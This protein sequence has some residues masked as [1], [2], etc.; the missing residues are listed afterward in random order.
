MRIAVFS[1]LASGGA[2]IAAWRL[3]RALSDFGHECSFF[4]L[5]SSGNPLQVP[6]LD[7]DDAFWV[8]SLFR[9]WSALTTPE[10]LSAHA[11]ELFSDTLT[12]LHVPSLLLK[13]IRDAELIHLHWVAGMLF[14]PALLSAVAG[15]KVIWTLHDENAFTGGCHYAGMCLNFKSRCCDCP[16]LRKPD[17][18][19]ASA[20]CFDLKKQLYPFLNPSFVAP[21][22]WLAER[23]KPSAL[24]RNFPVTVIPNSLSAESFQPARNKLALRRKLGLPDDAFIILSG[25]EHLSNPRKR[26]SLLFEA[27]DFLSEQ[28]FDIPVVL[29]LYGHGQPP[30]LAFPIHHFGYV[31]DEAIMVDLYGAADIFVHTS[32]QDNLPLSLCEAQACGTP[33]LCFDVGGCSETMI[34]EK[35]GFLVVEATKQALAEKLGTI[36]KN[37]D[38]LEGMSKAARA[39]AA[40]RFNPA[41]VAAAYM[42]LFENAQPAPGLKANDPIFSE[43]LQNQ[44][45]SL[46][47]FLQESSKEFFDQLSDVNNWLNDINGRLNGTD[48]QLNEVYGRLS[49]TDNQLGEVY[50]RLSGT[51]N[52]LGEIYGRLSGIDNQLSGV[53]GRLSG[54][55]NQLSEICGRLSGTDSQL[56]EVYDRLNGTDNQ[57]SEVYGRLSGIDSQL[58]EVYDRLNGINNRFSEVDGRVGK[59]EAQLEEQRTQLE[60]CMEYINN[61]RWNLRHP[62]RWFFRKLKRVVTNSHVMPPTSGR[63]IKFSVITPSFNSGK[64][65]EKAIESVLSQQYEQVEH[66]IVD[67]GST[68]NTLSV[69]KKYPALRWVSEPDRGQVHALNKGISMAT[70]DVIGF[71]NA[72]DYYNADAF[73]NAAG[74]F[75]VNTMAVFGNVHVYQE[76]TNQWWVNIPRTDFDSVIR[77]WEPQA[78]CVNPVGY[79]C[80]KE[81]CNDI[82][83]REENGAKHDLAFLLELAFR[84]PD[85]IKKLDTIFGVFLCGAD[86]QTTREQELSGYW[87]PENF[88]FIEEFL[89]T[90]PKDYQDKFRKDQLQGYDEREQRRRQVGM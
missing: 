60:G 44:I 2:G 31:A 56:S 69:L 78:F 45:G 71:L 28:S 64:T 77:H 86:T 42:E 14:S 16:L 40:E 70:G 35:T 89:L 49:G 68:D 73:L 46:A 36:I 85:S 76:A 65:I 11:T 15:K 18:G 90:R 34:P 38:S 61:F 79:F 10:V 3:T 67:G 62:F 55:D 12:G 72:D 47:S 4:V 20:R 50:G 74:A 33:T 59:I 83:Y 41:T 32:L 9:Q 26:A 27:L 7:N 43:L 13:D 25:S 17:Q 58:G 8:P 53:Y 29:M 5:E 24:L 75:D 22:V 87:V 30:E 23:A 52:Q 6:L 1:T 84:Y 66:I 37:R 48:N 82:P 80:R 88:A 39:F 57:L 63:K 81:V 54:T 21:S 19:D 51:D